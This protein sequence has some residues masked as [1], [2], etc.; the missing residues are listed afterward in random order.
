[1]DIASPILADR[2]IPAGD[3]YLRPA[4]LHALTPAELTRRTSALAPMIAAHAAE[5]ER[6]RRPTDAVWSALRRSGF[7]YQFVP[8]AFGGMAT[9]LDSFIDAS[10]PIAE[11]CASTA[12]VA[13]FCAK[14]NWLLAHFPLETQS[15]LWGGA[16]PYIVAPVVSAPPGRAVRVDG[17]VLVTGSWK[18]A[19]G[20]MHAD[21]VMA[22]ALLGDAD[23]GLPPRPIMTLF[24]AEKA[25]VLDTWYVDGMAGTGSNDVRVADLFVPEARTVS[26][27]AVMAGRGP[28]SRHYPEAIYRA[29]M[30][31]FFTVTLTIPALGA[32]RI[33]LSQFRAQLAGHVKPGAE[34]K[35][36]DKPAAQIRLAEADLMV[37]AAEVLIRD[38]GRRAV[39]A[40]AFDEPEQIPH[41]IAVRAQA[42]HAVSLC[43]KAALHLAEGAGSSVHR[44]DQPFQRA[45]RDVSV[46]ANHFA[47]DVD[48]AHEL[49]GRALLG[50][51]PNSAF[52]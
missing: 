27:A 51:P 29:P 35:Q 41:R 48:V 40:G 6:L 47:F 10:L 52:I 24:P 21:W 36:A 49:H 2:R 37:N 34:I 31:P 14:H 46:I 7:F 13:T 22:L 44:L 42:T 18:W 39:A 17:G 9:D 28:G 50:L 25:E 16:Y 15:E 3:D 43:R 1:M 33:A 38:A 19:S 23:D 12:W 4:E 32:A 5:A 8:K 30:F 20:I 45:V 26:L 11:A